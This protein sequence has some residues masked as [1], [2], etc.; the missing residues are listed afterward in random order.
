[1]DNFPMHKPTLVMLPGLVCDRTVWRSQ[2]DVLSA[3]AEC[4]VPCYDSL[5]SL[6]SM[7]QFVLA[8]APAQFMLAGHSMGGRIALE[9][10]RAAPERVMRLALLDTGYQPKQA[11]S[12][13]DA[14]TSQRLH[15]LEIANTAGMRT[16][17]REW[18]QG[19]VHPEHLQSEV[20]IEPILAM[21]ARHTAQHFA[22]QIRA[23]LNRPDATNVLSAINC[24]TLV[25]CGRQDDWSPLSRHEQIAKL[26]P[27]SV[28]E[29]IENSGHMSTMEQPAQVSAALQRWLFE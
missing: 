13:G 2:I 6:A 5:D 7:A 12:V 18:V 22:A 15:L 28:L 11:G 14:E 4:I 3:Y 9:I 29:V 26:I 20:L 16:M 1:M 27:G 10:M 24:P 25:L 21:I 17:G 19:M 23:L 8:N